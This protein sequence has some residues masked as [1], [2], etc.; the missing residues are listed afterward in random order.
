MCLGRSVDYGGDTSVPACCV[1]AGG[2]SDS[3]LAQEV[4]QGSP[5]RSS[6]SRVA[7][8]ANVSS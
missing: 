8:V 3:S 7:S 2:S 4:Q 5:T 1:F 6:C